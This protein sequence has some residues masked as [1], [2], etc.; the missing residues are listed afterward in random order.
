MSINDILESKDLIPGILLIVIIVFVVMGVVGFFRKIKRSI[1]D[2]KN[3]KSFAYSPN[4]FF[5][6][7]FCI[8]N[9]TPS[10]KINVQNNEN[11][12]ILA[13]EFYILEYDIY[14]KILQS[15]N[16]PKF[17]ATRTIPAYGF[18]TLRHRPSH[19]ATHKIQIFF[20]S[21]Y[22]NDGSFWGCKDASTKVI[23]EHTQ[24]LTLFKK[25]SADM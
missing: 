19:P 21:I 14:G 16:S 13:I 23:F 6:G 7:E 12:D 22:Y 11:K 1:I 9:N 25:S 3:K 20:Y 15:E 17:T 8:E 24:P 10:V 4:A 2:S 5:S 18:K